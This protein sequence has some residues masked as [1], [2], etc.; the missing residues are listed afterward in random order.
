MAALTQRYRARRAPVFA[1]AVGA[2]GLVASAA[3][4][5]LEP[6]LAAYAWLTAL[7]FVVSVSLGGLIF[8]MI[9]YSTGSRWPVAIRRLTET[10]AGAFLPLG[11][12]FVPLILASGK[13]YVWAGSRAP[14]GDRL[15]RLLEHQAPWLNQ[16]FFAVR[17][18]FYFAV[19]TSAAFLLRRWSLARDAAPG[20]RPQTKEK[21]LSAVLLPVVG[22][23]LT[24]ASFDW[25]MS[26][27]PAWVSSVFGV[28]WFAGG[29]V[30]SLGLVSVVTHVSSR[31]WAMGLLTRFHH[32]ALGRLVFGF[33][34]FWA[35]IAFFQALLVQMADKPEEAGFYV[36]RMAG[37][38]SGVLGL[39][40]AAKFVIP[41]VVLLPRR[42]KMSSGVVAAVG[43][44]VLG[45]H[46]VDVYWLV[47]PA[48]PGHGPV[49]GIWDLTALVA[50]AGSSVAFVVWRLDGR[51][52][53]PVG[54]PLLA[55]ALA[56]R[57]RT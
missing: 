53:L 5:V 1:A 52:L 3:G 12:L 6:E 37:G 45:G 29:F 56:Y 10:V 50:V 14:E 26:L 21:V 13:L 2:A 40:V 44:V 49:P 27:D 36:D 24:F 32:H 25:L 16:P 47:A 55:E 34:I 48:A 15:S 22:L 8:L 23:T 33:A 54:D 35:Y 42:M 39:A 46:Y 11:L 41:F 4:G 30:A 9:G 38:W 20:R 43:A 17:A 7:A 19:W 57:S 51:H 28:Y 18:L 31:R